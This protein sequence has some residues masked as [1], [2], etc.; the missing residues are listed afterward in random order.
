MVKLINDI[1]SQTNLLA[2]N[3]TI[4]AARAGEAGKGF[5]VVA[6]EVKALASQTARATEEITGHIAAV[7]EE[8]EAA[9][10]ATREIASTIER[11]SGIALGIT[12]AV[13]QQ[14]TA[15]NEISRN[16]QEAAR[17]TAEAA[18]NVHAVLQ[19]AQAT[20]QAS[21]QVSSAAGDLKDKSALLSRSVETFLREIRSA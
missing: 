1:A 14:G 21:A 9:V 15:T 5:A 12:E 13:R 4:E 8:A 11:I 16:I 10:A 6:N 3:A 7:Q 18:S 19:T 20:D 17:G 2:L